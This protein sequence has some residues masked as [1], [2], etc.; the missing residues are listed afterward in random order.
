MRM[1]KIA[2]NLLIGGVYLGKFTTSEA[3]IALNMANV[4]SIA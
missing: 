2:S 1:P 4:G 3:E